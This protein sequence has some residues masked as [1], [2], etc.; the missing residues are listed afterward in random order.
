VEIESEW[1]AAD[2]VLKMYGGPSRVFVNP[3]FASKERA[4]TWGTRLPT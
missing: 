2:G 1:T 4:R 3:G